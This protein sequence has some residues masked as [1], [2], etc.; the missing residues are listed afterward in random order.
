MKNNLQNNIMTKIQKADFSKKDIIMK[1]ITF[2]IPKLIKNKHP[3]Y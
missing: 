2:R 1:K 3:Q